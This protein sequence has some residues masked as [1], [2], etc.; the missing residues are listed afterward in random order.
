MYNQL[1]NMYNQTNKYVHCDRCKCFISKSDA[2]V[3]N[4]CPKCGERM[5]QTNA[6]DLD[7]MQSKRRLYKQCIRCDSIFFRPKD[8]RC[9][10]C[11][12][13]TLRRVR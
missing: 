5:K 7:T 1:P 8:D 2:P 13:P 6:Y 4:F 9:I 12:I 11:R 10:I 3:G